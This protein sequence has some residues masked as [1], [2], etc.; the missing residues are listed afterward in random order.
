M[1]SKIVIIGMLSLLGVCTAYAQQDPHFTQYM[2]NT[3]SVNPGYAGSRGALTLGGLYRNQWIGIDGAPI[4]QTF[5]VHSPVGNEKMGLGFSAVNDKI[6]PINQ[7]FLYADFAY[8]VK[9]SSTV[10]LGLGAKAGVNMFQPKLSTVST[11]T[12]NDPTFVNSNLQNTIAPN[13]GFGAYLYNDKWYVGMSAP[14]LIENS[15]KTGG[16][17]VVSEKRHFF[18]IGGLIL[19]VSDNIKLKP[20]LQAKV[21]QNAPLSLDATVEALINEKFSVGLAHRWKESVSVLAGYNITAQFKAGFA[22]DY[23]LSQ[24]QRYNN[25]SVELML[26]YDFIYKRD[27]I[28]SPRFF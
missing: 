27:K 7:T 1:K 4:T 22:F 26:Q 19:P 13:F 25:G 12:A 18:F 14:K 11:T 28:K 21:V 5:Y 20:T 3:I 8:H 15:L 24:L 9:L 17:N 23:T 10:K 16:G 2:Y 6:G